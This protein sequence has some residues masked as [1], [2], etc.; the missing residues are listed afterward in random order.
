MLTTHTV[1][2]VELLSCISLV[3]VAYMCSLIV[4]VC[5]C[6]INGLSQASLVA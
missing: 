6:V 4:C 5:V 2:L 1:A 3:K